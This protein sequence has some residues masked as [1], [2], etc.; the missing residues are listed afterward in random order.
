V[1]VGLEVD[2]G[3]PHAEGVEQHLV[4][5]AHHRASSTG[6][7]RVGASV[8]A[9]V[10]IRHLNSAPIMPSRSRGRDR[11]RLIMRDSQRI[12]R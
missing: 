4:Q 11:R 3:C 9:S 8:A 7:G 12:P 2:V 10:A 1:F 6:R 5:E